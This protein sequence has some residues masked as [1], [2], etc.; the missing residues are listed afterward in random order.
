MMMSKRN[1][2]KKLRDEEEATAHVFQ[3]FLTSFQSITNTPS[4][5]FIKSAILNPEQ[6]TTTAALPEG[7]I[8]LP[9]PLISNKDVSLKT[10][11]ECAKILKDTKI[12]KNKNKE[13]PRSN[14][15]LLKEE[16]KQRQLRKEDTLPVSASLQT[17]GYDPSSTN[18]FIANLNPKVSEE[19]L[20]IL[21]GR[22][23]ALA[24]VKIMWPRGEEKFRHYPNTNCGFVAFM[25]RKD[26]ERALRFLEYRDDMR[27]SWG[28]SVEIPSQPIYIPP[29]MTKLFLPPPYSGLPFNAQPLN[30]TYEKPRNNEELEV[31]LHNSVVKVTIPL[32]KR[33]LCIIHRIIEFVVREGPLFEA[34]IMMNEANNP[35]FSF[36]FDYKSSL[37]VYYRWK[38]YSVLHGDGQKLWSLKPFRMV[39]NGPIWIPP[40]PIDYT[41]GMPDHLISY[42][43][44]N[45]K[46]N[47]LSNAQ[48]SR[49]IDLIKNLNLSRAKILTAMSFCLNHS[50]AIRDSLSIIIDSLKNESTKPQSKIARLFLLSDIFWNCKK[51]NIK[52]E[53][54]ESSEDLKKIFQNLQLSYINMSTKFDKENFKRR[55]LSVLR[56]WNSGRLFPMIFIEKLEELFLANEYNEEEDV[57]SSDEPLDGAS[58]LKR[59]LTSNND[60]CILPKVENQ[61]FISSTWN[62]VDPKDLES[63][64]MSTQK[65]FELELCGQEN[66]QKKK[67]KKKRKRKDYEVTVT[68]KWDDSDNEH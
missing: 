38:L 46:S 1:Y 27:I 51:R 30:S 60:I 25:S 62:R 49:L 14:L 32:D 67:K 4:K 28:K 66:E 50:A 12:V 53:D 19:Q 42:D 31:L 26:A 65:L 15:E 11:I 56:S 18:L 37:H 54:Y 22:Y 52:I 61:H 20:M 6:P 16:I 47:L 41:A 40:V 10:A 43:K 2:E 36:L 55:I 13:K 48:S 34:L 68:S 17:D 59:T 7:Q 3:D 58:L 24:S 35:D 44:E 8:Y 9:K 45:V 63:Q 21:F 33:I 57:F 5:V 64:A 39:K 29:E 23:G